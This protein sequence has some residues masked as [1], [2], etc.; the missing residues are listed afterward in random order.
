M[1]YHISMFNS[2]GKLVT[3]TAMNR[4][5]E[6]IGRYVQGPTPVLKGSSTLCLK[7]FRTASKFKP[8]SI[9]SQRNTQLNFLQ[10]TWFYFVV[11]TKFQNRIRLFGRYSTGFTI[12]I[13][14]FKTI[15]KP[16]IGLKKILNVKRE[17]FRYRS[18]VPGVR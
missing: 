13:T 6:K 18:P 15:Q 5:I 17:P 14:I 2:C 10:K 11:L 7:S 1:N 8:I 12:K 4:F 9:I 3:D 16:K